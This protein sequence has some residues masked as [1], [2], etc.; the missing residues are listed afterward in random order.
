[1]DPTAVNI[2]NTH[3]T[4]RLTRLQV[5]MIGLSVIVV[6]LASFFAG[7]AWADEVNKRNDVVFNDRP[8]GRG[9]DYIEVYKKEGKGDKN[10]LYTLTQVVTPGGPFCT[11]VTGD[12]ERT[13]AITCAPREDV[14]HPELYRELN[15]GLFPDAAPR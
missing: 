10:Y 9:P 15:P 6:A 11:V 3:V 1:M 12:S 13:I 14:A 7:Q 2:S 5:L 4:H 8:T